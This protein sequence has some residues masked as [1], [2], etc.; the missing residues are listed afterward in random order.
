MDKLLIRLKSFLQNPLVWV[1]LIALIFRGFIDPMGFLDAE[2]AGK[3]NAGSPDAAT[4]LKNANLY[5]LI[6]RGEVNI[7]RTPVYLVFTGLHRQMFGKENM[8]AWIVFSQ[9]ILSLISAFFFYR[10]AEYFIKSRSC[11]V[12]ASLCYIVTVSVL[13][14]NNWILPE[15]LA[16]IFIVCWF[17]V[18][19]NYVKK[20]NY[21]KAFLIGFGVFMLV[22]LRPAFIGLL[23]LVFV[24]W[25][26]RFAAYIHTHIWKDAFG[27]LSSVIALVLVLGYCYQIYQKTGIFS[28]SLVS[29]GNQYICVIQSGLFQKDNSPVSRQMQKAANEYLENYSGK[30]NQLDLLGQVWYSSDGPI[31]FIVCKTTNPNLLLQSTNWL[32]SEDVSKNNYSKKE[33]ALVQN[34]HDMKDY[35]H[36]IIKKYPYDYAKFTLAKFLHKKTLFP[37]YLLALI[38][39]FLIFVLR[40]KAKH[41]PILHIIFWLLLSGLLFTALAAAQDEYLRLSLPAFPFV[42]MIPFQLLNAFCW[43]C[44]DNFAEE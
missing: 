23:L 5:G 38:E 18:L 42:V 44:N 41:I 6:F 30:T 31:N 4:Y 36:Y 29:L 22:M 8:L 2:R 33:V 27:L 12:L 14:L 24:F 26:M 25:G 28:I 11:V 16:V 21:F 35:T 9:R 7:T 37:V 40:K 43:R 20:P 13:L 19:I 15:S 39:L 1:M 17:Y 3:P 32:P 10:I 34:F